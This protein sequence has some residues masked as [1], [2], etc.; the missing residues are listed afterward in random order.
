MKQNLQPPRLSQILVRFWTETN[1]SMTVE[2]VL[3]FPLLIWAYVG[4]FVFFHAYQAQNSNLKAAYTVADMVTRQTDPLDQ[5]YL[6]GLNRVYDFIVRT[7][8]P[9]WIRVTSITW[10]ED[11]DEYQVI[12]SKG[13]NGQIGWTTETLKL[14]EAEIPV[15]ADGETSVI[16]EA[17]NT[18]TPALN[19]G[20]SNVTFN[21]FVVTSP[22]FASQICWE[23]S[24][25]SGA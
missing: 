16:V 19:V 3:L 10:N 5:S 20:F 14:R 13:T 25:L 15:L 6:D 23:N 9:T 8:S 12:W 18:Y 17:F 4:S 7:P 11:A 21:N 22:R 1:A 24:C 2:A